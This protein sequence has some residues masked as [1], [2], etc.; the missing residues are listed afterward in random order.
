[1]RSATKS[2]LGKDPEYLAWIASQPCLCCEI[3]QRNIRAWLSGWQI[4]DEVIPERGQGSKT[5][6]AHVGP[7]G[8]SQKCPDKETLPLCGWEHHREGKL[9]IHKLGRAFWAMWNID[10]EREITKY[11][12]RYE[13]ECTAALFRDDAA[14]P[15]V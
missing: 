2:R 1:M 9:S 14:G 12:D 15:A 6:A 3:M 7:R 11:Q 4:G 13:T 8:L 5:E 10:R